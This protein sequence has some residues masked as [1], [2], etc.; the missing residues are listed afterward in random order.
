MKLSISNIAWSVEYD[1]EM[2]T[3]LADNGFDGIE[4]APTRIFP[5]TPYDRLAEAEEYS[6]RLKDSYG[7]SILSIQ[8]IWY[9]IT[10]SIFGSDSDRKKLVEY[11]K[12]A[13]DFT[14][15]LGCRNLV[16][17]CPKNRAIPP[18]TANYLS[19]A[20]DFFCAVGTYAADCG[21]CAAIEPNP[22]IYNTN[23][24]NTTTEAFDLCKKLNN[25]GIKINLDLGT[26]I[27]YGEKTEILKDNI[28]LINHIHVSEPY[29][30]P[31]EKRHLH[32]ELISELRELKYSKCIS[33]EMGSPNDLELVKK[34][35]LY[36]KELLE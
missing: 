14:K 19:V 33:V 7:L 1:D 30:A 28:A 6:K 13:I 24:I 3:F 17:G 36:I 32:R 29:L 25:P 15:A 5:E 34:S 8:S 9:G 23:F 4:A 2:Y 35:A 20:C 10:E 18:G 21:V 16:Y 26:M 27:H 11:T 12:K 22:P 31:I